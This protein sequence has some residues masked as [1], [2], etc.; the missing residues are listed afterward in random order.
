MLLR[1]KRICHARLPQRSI[2]DPLRRRDE[3]F[4]LRQETNYQIAN[5]IALAAPVSNPRGRSTKQ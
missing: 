1:V 5:G 4:V 3:P 2:R